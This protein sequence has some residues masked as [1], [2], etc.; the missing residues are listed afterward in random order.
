ETQFEPLLVDRDADRLRVH[1]ATGMIAGMLDCSIEDALARLRGR[2]FVEGITLYEL[3][4]RVI[5][6]DVRLEK[7]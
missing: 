2:A 3:A 1:Q 7:P 5:A 6:G 4:S